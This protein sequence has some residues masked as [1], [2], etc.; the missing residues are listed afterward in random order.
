MQFFFR[1][2]QFGMALTTIITGFL[3]LH[4]NYNLDLTSIKAIL[5]FWPIIPA[6]LIIYFIILF[7]NETLLIYF[8]PDV[9]E[10]E[11]ME[12]ASRMLR[13]NYSSHQ[14][15]DLVEMSALNCMISYLKREDK[16][17]V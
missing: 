13:N 3:T 17:D 4:R 2:K 5:H 6:F 11:G 7:I 1:T 10:K 12:L 14:T 9:L 8:Y 16:S 15:S